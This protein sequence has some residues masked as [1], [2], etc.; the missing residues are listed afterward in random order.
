MMIIPQVLKS[1]PVKEEYV[2]FKVGD[3]IKHRHYSTLWR[4]KHIDEVLGLYI[5]SYDKK[6]IDSTEWVCEFHQLFVDSRF[7]LKREILFEE[8]M[9]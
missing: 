7:T 9:S 1:W 6:N 5:L 8:T 2:K 4:I 3:I